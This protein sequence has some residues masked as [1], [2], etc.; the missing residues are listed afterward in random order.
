[1]AAPKD[2]PKDTPKNTPKNTPKDTP[3]HGPTVRVTGIMAFSRIEPASDGPIFAAL[4]YAGKCPVAS[5][6][7]CNRVDR[8]IG[9]ES[10]PHIVD[11]G[12]RPAKPGI[13]PA[14]ML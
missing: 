7:R 2:T 9:S 5:A 13:R 14:S 11:P 6:K 12:F 8:E 4:E 10:V 1:M 3:K